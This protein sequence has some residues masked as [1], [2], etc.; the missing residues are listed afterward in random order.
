[1][2]TKL[3]PGVG[4]IPCPAYRGNEP[5]IFISYAHVDSKLVFEEIKRFNE[6]G[7]NVWYDEGIAP[8]NEWTDEIAEAL[9]GCALFVLM[10]TPRSVDRVNVQNEVNYAL[11]E[12]KPFLAIHLEET[13]L[14]GGMK[15]RI[16]IKHAILKYKMTQEEYAW[17]VSE[18]FKRL[19]LTAN[20]TPPPPPPEKKKS[21]WLLPV[22]IAVLLAAA[23][24][25]YF[26]GPWQ[27]GGV[28]DAT[29]IGPA[30]TGTE[31]TETRAPT[32]APKITATPEAAAEP[33]V[34]PKV[35]VQ[36][37]AAATPRPTATPV[38]TA[39]PTPAGT[40]QP[41]A[42]PKPTAEPAVHVSAAGILPSVEVTGPVMKITL[43]SG[44]IIEG[45]Q[46]TVKTYFTLSQLKGLYLTG[47]TY[48]SHT[49]DDE[50]K[51]SHITTDDPFSDG[52]DWS[53]NYSNTA[54]NTSEAKD[55]SFSIS[56]ADGTRLISLFNV[57]E[58]SVES[59]K[60]VTVVQ[61]EEY[62]RAG[63]EMPLGGTYPFNPSGTVRVYL[64]NG[65]VYTT[66]P[67]AFSKF[68]T[69]NTYLY[70]DKHPEYAQTRDFWIEE[71]KTL[72]F[73]LSDSDSSFG[74]IRI[75]GELANGEPVSKY[76]H[77][78]GNES[79]IYTLEKSIVPLK[80]SEIEHIEVDMSSTPDFSRIRAGRITLTDG[81]VFELP[82]TAMEYNHYEGGG[83]VR[84]HPVYNY[85]FY[86]GSA[87]Y[88]YGAGY[89][90]AEQELPFSTIKT[91]EFIQGD[92]YGDREFPATVTYRDG[93]TE[94]VNFR[95]YNYYGNY[96]D[97]Y[98]PSRY[99]INLSRSRFSIAK[100]EF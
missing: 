22:I 24:C 100:I 9:S 71:A 85:F 17:K 48:L 52:Y 11:D 60:T 27:D 66:Y 16:N 59:E 41:T 35:T 86:I 2:K 36:P 6:M 67:D 88:E 82:V 43:F 96:L 94:T 63:T 69:A 18:A 78:N 93:R 73:S 98:L 29:A 33:T 12:N 75:T 37:T 8:G 20:S 99:S 76:M 44:E 34:T 40:P 90:E 38:V 45:P 87:E 39:T 30:V 46:S 53:H 3:V 65:T 89:K 13:E 79:R 55:Q 81:T 19:G 64:K 25:L 26:F 83:F 91:I 1:M 15:L 58:I 74:Y 42:A 57:K 92:N 70:K 10:V 56:T 14:K 49:R 50:N 4:R 31:T 77:V 5:Y 62:E 54:W 68:T 7:F 72:Y 80:E 47:I 84:P 21:K 95:F 51:I 97:F 23:A 61:E 28:K 32:E